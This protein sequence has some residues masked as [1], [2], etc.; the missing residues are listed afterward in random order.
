MVVVCESAK[1]NKSRK[2]KQRADTQATT[3]SCF[4]LWARLKK[5]F[6]ENIVHLNWTKESEFKGYFDY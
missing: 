4:P 1:T 6:I 5:S 3:H 2:L